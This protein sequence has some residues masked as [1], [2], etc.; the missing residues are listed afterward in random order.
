M[1]Q[2]LFP[3]A[4]L[5]FRALPLFGSVADGFD[6]WLA[7]SGYTPGSRESSIRFLVHAG[8]GFTEAKRP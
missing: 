5:K 4:H 1:L 8:C 2:S 3:K 6:D 7:T